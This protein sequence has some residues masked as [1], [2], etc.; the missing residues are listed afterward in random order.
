MVDRRSRPSRCVE[1][2]SVGAFLFAVLAELIFVSPLRAQEVISF[3]SRDAAHTTITALLFKPAGAGPFPA[4]VAMHGCG[5]LWTRRSGRPMPREL[6]WANILAARGYVVLLPDS[7]RPRGVVH[8]CADRAPRAR[9]Q[10]ERVGDAYGALVYL[11]SQPFIVAGRVGLIGWSHGGGSVMFAVAKDSPA[12]VAD[13]PGGGFRAAVAF[14]PGWCSARR[15]GAEWSPVAPFLLEVGAADD[16]APAAP[17]A[18]VVQS[19]ID[20]GATARLQI[21]P[22]AYHDFDWPGMAVRSR[23]PSPGKTVHTGENP[24]ARA[25]ALREVPDFLDAYLKK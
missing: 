5:G 9:P 10:V 4:V 20:R 3:P 11:Q 23:T 15:L 14:Y 25:D 7:F 8:A 21:H 16:W 12:R 13:S 6:A 1:A 24:Q 22:G 18:Q 2:R 19:A 17:C